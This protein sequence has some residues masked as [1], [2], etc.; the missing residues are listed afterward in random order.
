MKTRSAI[1]DPRPGDIVRSCYE[2]IGE[3]HVTGMSD[4]D[5]S[6]YR[7]KPSGKRFLGSCFKTT[8]LQWCRAH[9]VEII[10]L[11]E[12]YEAMLPPTDKS[13]T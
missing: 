7:V 4:W 10:Q 3:R 9:R 8:W 12:P 1:D 11:G 13:E 5:V 2:S 6:Y